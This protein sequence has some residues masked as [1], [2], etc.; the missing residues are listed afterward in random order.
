MNVLVT[1]RE[2]K[3]S[4]GSMLLSSKKPPYE[5]LQTAFN[6]QTDSHIPKGMGENLLLADLT[7]ISQLRYGFRK[8]WE[9]TE[10]QI[11]VYGHTDSFDPEEPLDYVF[12]ADMTAD[13]MLARLNSGNTVTLRRI[14]VED[15]WL[16]DPFF[17][18][19][20]ELSP[21]EPETDNLED[22][23]DYL[24]RSYKM[25]ADTFG[26]DINLQSP[27]T[28]HLLPTPDFFNPVVETLF[29]NDP[30][31]TPYDVQ[32][33]LDHQPTSDLIMWASIDATWTP[34]LNITFE[35]RKTRTNIHLR[36][37]QDPILLYA[38]EKPRKDWELQR[39][40][41]YDAAVRAIENQNPLVDTVWESLQAAMERTPK[42]NRLAAIKVFAANLAEWKA[43]TDRILE[44]AGTAE[45]RLYE[46]TNP[47]PFLPN[48]FLAIPEKTLRFWYK[49]MRVYDRHVEKLIRAI[50][51]EC[52]VQVPENAAIS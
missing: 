42:E 25:D 35:M 21:V 43:T 45:V 32:Y 51:S 24:R 50:L 36:D 37:L 23:A 40:Q 6:T 29:I 8:G 15:D 26:Y 19:M 44:Q 27:N 30:D 39:Q 38:L 4:L 28:Q 17:H 33:L 1:E 16:Q 18:W 20:T 11:V 22:I 14:Q 52:Y 12:C 48:P 31:E 2:I 3:W 34:M 47:K 5:L 41:A 13:E 9:H 49:Q 46:S 10:N 7:Y